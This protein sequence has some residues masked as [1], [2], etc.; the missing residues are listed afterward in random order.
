QCA[1]HRICSSICDEMQ[2]QHRRDRCQ[3]TRGSHAG[4][5]TD[6]GSVSACGEDAHGPER[7]GSGGPDPSGRPPS[8]T[9]GF[10]Y[11]WPGVRPRSDVSALS[12]KQAIMIDCFIRGW[13]A[14]GHGREVVAWLTS[15]RYCR[16]WRGRAPE[17]TT[18]WRSWNLPSETIN[19]D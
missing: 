11:T 16:I 8:S 1:A 14:A 18:W 2:D 9:W 7:V 13:H 12:V 10:P 4:R 6:S 19:H 15:S 3:Q 5:V 17:W